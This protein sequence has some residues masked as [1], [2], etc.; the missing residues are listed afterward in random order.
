MEH[1]QADGQIT[2]V[3]GELRFAGLAFLVQHFETRNDHT[4]QLDD[5]G[6]RDVRHDAQCEDRQLEH[7]AAGEE[8]DQTDEVLG[9]RA[10]LAD[11]LLDDFDVD[12]RC[13][14]E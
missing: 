2:G 11:A 1:R 7:G 4:Q 14:D 9:Y 3:L 13:R 10:H 12:T 6:C 8:V 5:D